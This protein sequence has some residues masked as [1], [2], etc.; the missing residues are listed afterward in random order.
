[1]PTLIVGLLVAALLFFAA[2]RWCVSPNRAAAAGAAADAVGAAAAAMPTR[3]RKRPNRAAAIAAE[4]KT[5]RRLHIPCGRLFLR[6]WG[7]HRC[8]L[9]GIDWGKGGFSMVIHVVQPGDSLYRIAREHQVPLPLLIAQNEPA[10]AVPADT[11]ADGRR[12][13]AN[14]DAHRPAGETLTGIAAQYNTTVLALLQNNPQLGGSDRI[15][16]GQLL[17]I[18]YGPKA[19]DI[20]GQWLRLPVD[21]PAGAAQDAA[22]PDVLIG[23]LLWF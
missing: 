11:R 13:A 6:L 9:R 12:A 15:R 5:G 4:N 17:V 10:R 7:G 14:T 8:M 22:L 3:L 18:S 2:R 16:A 23:F 19:R 21:R 1:M 20:C